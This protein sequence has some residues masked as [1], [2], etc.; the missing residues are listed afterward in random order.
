MSRRAALVTGASGGIGRAV[1]VELAAQGFDVAVGWSGS[2]DNA[3]ETLRLVRGAGGEGICVRAD[4]SDPAAVRSMFEQ[5]RVC[6]GEPYALVCCAGIAQQKMLCDITD[7][8]WSRMISINLGGTFY[9]CREAASGMVRQ[10]RGAIVTLSSVWG[11]HGA[12]CESHY[13]ASKAGIIGLTQALADE[14]APSGIRV[15]CVAPGVIDTQMNSILD[16]QTM[17]Q[18]AQE[19]P[20]GALGTPE[21]VAKTVAFLLSDAAS[22]IT[23]ATV[24]VTGGF[25]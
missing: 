24:P 13:S 12:S 11:L 20:L 16:A 5:V 21:Q 9:C 18:L 1:A 15:N 22:Y 3:L 10:K 2:E 8:D 25:R 23:G 14:L 7:D 4:V 6:L 19:T 17:E